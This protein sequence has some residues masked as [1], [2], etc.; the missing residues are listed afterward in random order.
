MHEDLESGVAKQHNDMAHD[1]PHAREKH[2]INRAPWLRAAVL[3]ANDGIVSIG[4]LLMGVS[5]S[6][7]HNVILA[8][9]SALVGGALSMAL[10]ELVSVYSQKDTEKAD[11]A[12]EIA[13]QN[14]GPEARERELI[15]LQDIYISR[16]VETDTARAVAEQLTKKDVIKAHAREELGIDV[17][18]L[19]KPWQAA[20]V[21][22]GSFAVGAAIPLLS[23]IFIT[24]SD[25]RVGV[26]AGTSII[27]L[28][29][30]GA[31]GSILGGA[32]AWVGAS[33]V[34]IG[35]AIALGATYGIGRAIQ[36]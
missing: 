18:D 34:V 26:T 19:A 1:K 9:V 32:A 23:A 4:S 15:E 35:G 29:I 13:E 8:G 12:R 25:V 31:T 22:C 20:F 7:R 3:G 21:S 36:H 2:Y 17:D 16:G 30:C 10:G 33:R 14:K 28:A 27:A 5:Q 11:I 6:D 24:S